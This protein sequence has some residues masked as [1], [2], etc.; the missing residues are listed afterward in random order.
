MGRWINATNKSNECNQNELCKSATAKPVK[1]INMD[2]TTCNLNEGLEK[3]VQNNYI[4][5]DSNDAGYR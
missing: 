5:T 4:E 2:G 1:Q 3:N